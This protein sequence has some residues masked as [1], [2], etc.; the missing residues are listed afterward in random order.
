MCFVVNAQESQKLIKKADSKVAGYYLDTE[1]NQAKLWEAKE[2]V[3]QAISDPSIAQEFRTWTVNGKVYN[4]VCSYESDSILITQQFNL[5]YTLKYPKAAI[6]AYESWLKALEFATKQREKEEVLSALTET[7]RYLNNY[8]LKLYEVS[9]NKAAYQSFVAVVNINM[10][11]T[12]AEMKSIFTKPEDLLEQKYLAA[13]CAVNADMLDE[14]APILEDLIANNYNKPYIY[15]G[16]F[17]YY[18]LSDSVKAEQVLEKG[19][20]AFPKETS[21]LFTEI[22]YFLKKGRLND[23]VDKLKIAIE[24]E[25]NNVSVH[26]TL[27]NVYDNLCQKSW[28]EDNMEKGN[29]Y[30]SEAEKNYLNALKI[31][32]T[33][34][35][36]LYSL[37][38]LYYNKAALLSKEVN[39]LSADY[40]KEG[41]K[42]YNEKKLEME[43]YFDKALPH[44]EKAELASP[45]DKNTLIALKEIYAKKSQFDKSNAYKTKLESLSE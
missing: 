41:T 31:K 25:P 15:E 21:L 19:R 43:G 11:V 14:A 33:D 37:G 4:A 26:T 12:K 13:A 16:L 23:L 5:K 8:G 38:A 42:K 3:D 27:G 22:N 28:D 45:N 9:D 36:A 20:K 6:T 32:G 7:S 40:S 24:Q 35:T 1:A 29:E 39:K 17:K 10:L 30:Y 44:F 34:F 2:L 18:A